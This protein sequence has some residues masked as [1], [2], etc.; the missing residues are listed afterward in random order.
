MVWCNLRSDRLFSRWR[1]TSRPYRGGS[2]AG[3]DSR[4]GASCRQRRLTVLSASR[5]PGCESGEC[6]AEIDAPV[7]RTDDGL[8][9]A[10]R[11]D[12]WG[13]VAPELARV[14]AC[15]LSTRIE[16]ANRRRGHLQTPPALPLRLAPV[17]LQC[18]CRLLGSSRLSVTC[19]VG[20][21][22]RFSPNAIRTTPTE[23]IPKQH[24]GFGFGGSRRGV[25]RYR[26]KPPL[27]PQN[28]AEPCGR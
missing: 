19:F 17:T 2:P 1:T 15:L 24:S 8:F 11:G 14:Y 6:E 18:F 7:G 10:Q 28:R 26:N 25:R 4:A 13:T 3:E 16:G 20:R 27:Y 12:R 23:Q 22:V 21:P 5:G 9:T